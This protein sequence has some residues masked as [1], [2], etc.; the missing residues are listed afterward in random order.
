[1]KLSSKTEKFL[2]QINPKTKLG[3]IRN[4]VKDIKKNHELAMELL[5]SGKFLPG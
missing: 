3:D 4:I 1:M 2:T 5:S